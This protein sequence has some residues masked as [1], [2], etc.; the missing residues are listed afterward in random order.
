M[1]L[2]NISLCGK[3][4]QVNVKSEQ[5]NKKIYLEYNLQFE[6]HIHVP[7]LK[8]N[9]LKYYVHNSHLSQGI[10]VIFNLFWIS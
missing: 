2:K 5:Q 7:K 6:K 3:L 8:G 4:L 9:I 10:M 1:Y